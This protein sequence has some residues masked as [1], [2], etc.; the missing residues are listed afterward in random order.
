MRGKLLVQEAELGLLGSNFL[1]TDMDSVEQKVVIS[2]SV[3]EFKEAKLLQV[4]VGGQDI[5]ALGGTQYMGL[6]SN[7]SKKSNKNCGSSVVKP[8]DSTVLDASHILIYLVLI[9]IF[10]ILQ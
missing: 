2:M 1:E 8:C 6:D 4:K 9:G 5:L 10:P 3:E 7:D